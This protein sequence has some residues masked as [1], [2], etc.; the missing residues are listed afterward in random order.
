MSWEGR[1]TESI[2]LLQ[3]GAVHIYPLS[4]SFPFNLAVVCC[5]INNGLGS[6]LWAI[7]AFHVGWTLAK[8]MLLQETAPQPNT[9]ANQRPPFQEAST[10]WTIPEDSSVWQLLDR[11]KE[12]DFEIQTER[13]ELA[14]A[15]KMTHSPAN[16]TTKTKL[17]PHFGSGIKCLCMCDLTCCMCLVFI[18]RCCKMHALCIS[19]STHPPPV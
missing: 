12:P 14:A 8:W 2:T 1:L 3:A 18:T 13:D 7:V 5:C 17:K 15:C 11:V 19:C 4:C 9:R 6:H 16:V 10:H